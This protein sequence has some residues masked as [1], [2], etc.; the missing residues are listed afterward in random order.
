M[1]SHIFFNLPN[2]VLSILLKTTKI[3][4]ISSEH[5]ISKAQFF[6]YKKETFCIEVINFVFKHTVKGMKGMMVHCKYILT[7]FLLKTEHYELHNFFDLGIGSPIFFHPKMTIFSDLGCNKMGLWMPKSKNGDHFLSPTISI[8]GG[9]A[10]CFTLISFSGEF[11]ANFEN[12][13]F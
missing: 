1:T 2:L 8:N 6:I 10:P 7:Y 13:V 4:F 9:T 12:R 5:I 3:Q 11:W